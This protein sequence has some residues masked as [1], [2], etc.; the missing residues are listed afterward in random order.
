[1]RH[2]EPHMYAGFA[3]FA[4]M[5][6]TGLLVFNGIA[7]KLCHLYPETLLFLRKNSTL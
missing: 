7:Y 6:V 4:V 2:F 3:G 1:M 5:A